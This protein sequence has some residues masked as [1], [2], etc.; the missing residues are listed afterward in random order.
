MAQ[1]RVPRTLYRQLLAWCRQYQ[2]VPFDGVPP[3]TLTPPQVNA[4][5]LRR[6]RSMRTF[7]DNNHIKDSTKHAKWRHPAHAALYNADVSVDDEM[8]VFPTVYNANQLRDVI[9]SVYWL[10]NVNTLSDIDGSDD[11]N[12]VDGI[13]IEPLPESVKEQISLAFDA[14]KSCNQLSSSELD[15]RR[16]R[17][18]SSIEIRQ[19]ESHNED[20]PNVK[21]H[22]GQVVAQKKKGWR[23]VI[24]G[25]TVEEEKSSVQNRL[26]SL[27]TKQY[28]LTE[29]N[30]DGEVQ[31]DNEISDEQKIKYTILVDV[32]DATLLESSKIVSLEQQKDLYLVDPW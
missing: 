21:Y 7:L 31:D 32:N 13:S 18:Q 2:D 20:A 28:T 4:R 24:V 27:T 19:K 8:I 3:L 12:E 1:N 5:A 9:R 10:N 6:L 17:R 16:N 15:S 22:V 26:T 30:A 23:G 11:G 14:I 29:N 25:W